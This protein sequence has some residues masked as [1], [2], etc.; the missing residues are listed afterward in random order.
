MTNTRTDFFR[1]AAVL[2]AAAWACGASTAASA[3]ANAARAEAL[4]Y[5]QACMAGQTH[6][7]RATCLKEANNYLAELKRNP[8]QFQGKEGLEGNA[9]AR[10]EPMTGSERTACMARA[11]GLGKVSGSVE[12]GGVYR[13]LVTVETQ[14]PVPQPMPASAPAPAPQPPAPAPQP[15]IPAPPASGPSK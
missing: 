3:D 9:K 1:T 10:C 4:K 5:R 13:E 8:G 14:K 6:Q 2:L 7:D 12:S 15:P 11:S